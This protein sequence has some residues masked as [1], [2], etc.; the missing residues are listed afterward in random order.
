MNV[1]NKKMLQIHMSEYTEGGMLHSI[2]RNLY[3]ETVENLKEE[4]NWS[5]LKYKICYIHWVIF[6]IIV[7]FV[8]VDILQRPDLHF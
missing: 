7:S 6:Q 5:L 2:E 1:D 8:S 4:R 3:L